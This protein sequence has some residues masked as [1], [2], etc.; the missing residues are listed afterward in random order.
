LIKSGKALEVARNVNIVI[1][2]KTGTLTKGEPVTTDVIAVKNGFD[3]KNILRLAASI[4]KN[5]EHPL[6]QAIVKK[7]QEENL[8]M[9]EVTDFQAIPGKGVRSEL[10]IQ[11]SKIKILFGTRKLMRDNGMDASVVEDK[12]AEL[13]NQGKTAMILAFN[14]EIVGIIAVADTLKEF[15]K[16]AVETGE[17][18]K[19][20]TPRDSIFLTYK[21]HNSP[22]SNL[23]GRS[24]MMG[25]PGLLWVHGINYQD[26]EKDINE[27]FAGA[28]NAKPLIEKN[29]I[30]YIVVESSDPQDMYINRAFLNQYPIILDSGNYSIYKVR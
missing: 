10:K 27:I 11:N 13:E 22:V 24:I 5:S 3:G 8:Q 15:S 7:A 6:A 1:F 23:A 9:E 29:S 25:Y 12:M 21:L 20:I 18:L 16:E 30:D 2:D 17:K 26:R 28:D 4:E 19:E 14:N